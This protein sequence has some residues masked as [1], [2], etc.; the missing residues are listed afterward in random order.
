MNCSYKNN[1]NP[2]GNYSQNNKK[3]FNGRFPKNDCYSQNYPS[4]GTYYTKQVEYEEGSTASSDEGQDFNARALEGFAIKVCG[5]MVVQNDYIEL[6]DQDVKMFK[7]AAS[8]ELA[9]PR[10][11]D[12]PLP[13][14]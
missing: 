2:S 13:K 8:K 6:V 3:R 10:Q 9:L 12:L 5:D 11:D 1:Y 4:Y 14:F 7:F